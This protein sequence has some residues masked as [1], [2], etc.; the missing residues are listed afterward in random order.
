MILSVAQYQAVLNHIQNSPDLNTFPNNDDG[1]FAIAVLLNVTAVPDFWV[2]RTD[3]TRSNVYN[4]VSPDGTS[5]SWQTYKGQTQGEQGAW[6]QM[7]MGDRAD[8][9]KPNL[10]AGISNIFGAGNAQT[11][12]CLSMGRRPARRIEKLLATG[13]G[14]TGSPAVMNGEGT[15]TGSQVGD[16][17]ANS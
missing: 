17:R 7:F 15:I 12:H 2:W 11:L 16:A 4:E 6:T 14:T 5:W 13:S 1:N 8:F 3:V 10:R 9:S